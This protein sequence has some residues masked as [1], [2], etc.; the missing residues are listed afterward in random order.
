MTQVVHEC[1]RA[2]ESEKASQGRRQD[3][4]YA[5]RGESSAMSA[6]LPADNAS[7]Q[8]G[9]AGTSANSWPLVILVL[10]RRRPHLAQ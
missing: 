3:V 6:S 2:A 5:A 7:S 8:V 10:G 4:S 1:I 9:H